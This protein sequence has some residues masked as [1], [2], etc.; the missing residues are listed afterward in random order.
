[1]KFPEVVDYMKEEER[2]EYWKSFFETEDSFFRSAPY[3]LASFAET[4]GADVRRLVISEAAVEGDCLNVST[5][6][7]KPARIVLH[8]LIS[9]S[10]MMTKNE[11]QQL[12]NLL[13]VSRPGRLVRKVP[14]VS[15]SA[16]NSLLD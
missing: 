2:R 16:K 13:L 8:S 5:G 3:F 12:A 9:L 1:M 10:P 14:R 6:S 7:D 4:D 15:R 11:V